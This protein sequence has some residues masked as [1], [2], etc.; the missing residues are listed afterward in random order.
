MLNRLI[1]NS[2]LFIYANYFFVAT[3]KGH[4]LPTNNHPLKTY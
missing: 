3:G 4:D 1:A 2:P